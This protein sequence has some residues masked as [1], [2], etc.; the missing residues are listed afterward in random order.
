M[1][2]IGALVDYPHPVIYSGGPESIGVQFVV[3]DS[4]SL[5]GA[6]AAWPS[7]NAAIY[8]PFR[9]GYIYTSV[10]MFWLNGTTVGTNHVDVGIYDFQGNQLVHSGSTLTSGASVIQSVSI[11]TTLEPGLYYMAMAMD[12]TTD[13][14]ARGNI[15]G[16]QSV[17]NGWGMHQQATAFALPSTASFSSVTSGYIPALA[18]TSNSTI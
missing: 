6:T 2:D 18:I 8:I 16:S 12:G 10:K 1:S 13:T 9:I 11:S 15:G 7:S 4:T 14:I 3:Q 5:T 17:L